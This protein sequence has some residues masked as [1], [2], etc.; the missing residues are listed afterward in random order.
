MKFGDPGDESYKYPATYLVPEQRNL[1][2][3]IP[4]SPLLL[5]LNA[6]LE[7]QPRKKKLL[8]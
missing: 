7:N 5:V 1:I 8:H 2:K 3:D 6:V 4:T